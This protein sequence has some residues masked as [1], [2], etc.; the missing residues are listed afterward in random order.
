MSGAPH[1]HDEHDLALPPDSVREITPVATPALNPELTVPSEDRWMDP[2]KEAAPSATIDPNTDLTSYEAGVIRPPDSS[3]ATGSEPR[4]SVPIESDWAPVME[5]TV[6]DIFS[7][8][9]WV[10]C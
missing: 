7:T 3:P 9:P 6:V 8:R 5:F 4:A 1:S 2:A 10:M